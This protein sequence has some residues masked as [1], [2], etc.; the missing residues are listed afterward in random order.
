MQGFLFPMICLALSM[1]LSLTCI[2][3][4]FLRT[5]KRLLADMLAGSKVAKIS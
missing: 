5:D 3:M 2:L 4:V 1:V